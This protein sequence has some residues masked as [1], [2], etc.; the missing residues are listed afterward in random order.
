V[1]RVDGAPITIHDFVSES[2]RLHAVPQALEEPAVFLQRLVDRQALVSLAL[3]EGVQRDPEL[4]RQY[5]NMLIGALRERLLAPRL[6]ELVVT[7]AGVQAHYDANQDRY[8]I[9]GS[10]RLAVLR[11]QCRPD[12]QPETKDQLESVRQQVSATD[13][14]AVGFGALAVANSD[15]QASRYQG[16]DIGWLR[17]GKGPSWLPPEV[18]A[19]AWELATPGQVSE[20]VALEQAVFLL[21]LIE[22]KDA[23]VRPLADVAPAIRS[24]LLAARRREAEEA[25]VSQACEAVAVAVD[26][27]ALAGAVRELRGR[28]TE[29]RGEPQPPPVP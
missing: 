23:G 3:R 20:V 19:V 11:L 25:F 5:D 17:D 16:G 26:Q 2:E 18:I 29:T 10:I 24:E 21:R 22:R 4:S 6:A 9:A 1:A 8:R 12:R 28:A 7:D 14:P 13:G 15:H 27:S